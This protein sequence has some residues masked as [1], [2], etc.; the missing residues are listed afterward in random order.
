METPTQRGDFRGPPYH[1]AA[2][3]EALERPLLV[4]SSKP[5]PRGFTL[6]EMMVVAVIMGVL[7]ALAI[8]NYARVRERAMIARAIGDI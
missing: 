6:I 4:S 8:P 1:A 3:E 5:R 2:P 7:A